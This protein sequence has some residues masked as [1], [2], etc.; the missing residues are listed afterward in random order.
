[1]IT[2]QRI[3]Y[4]CDFIEATDCFGNGVEIKGGVC[5]FL[6][7]R[8]HKGLCHVRTVEKDK[9]S[10]ANRYL[11]EDGVDSFIRRNEGVS[12]Y[13]KVKAFDEPRI[14]DLVSSQKPFGLG[15]AF[16]GRKRALPGDVKIFENG[17]TGFVSPGDITK[18]TDLIGKFKVY[19]SAG[20]NGGDAFPHQIIG[21]P[22]LGE[23][24][25]CC[26]ETY[27][28]IGCFDSEEY[29]QNLITYILIKSCK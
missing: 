17:G 15:T 13:H 2:D 16:H 25:T 22:I 29:A 26:S 12:I 8:D 7:D 9:L 6:W 24:N 20:Y 11:K 14:S 19:I 28:S 1:M 21:R 10:E 27:I 4:L 18:S 5:Y 3:R 23:P